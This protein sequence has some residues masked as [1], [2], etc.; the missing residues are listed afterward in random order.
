MSA[1]NALQE[2][3]QK[4]RL[5]TPIYKCSRRGGTD[6]SPLFKARV[7]LHDRRVFKATGPNKKKAESNAAKKALK[8][9]TNKKSLVCIPENT[10][11]KKFSSV[12][13]SPLEGRN[14]W[15]RLHPRLRSTKKT[16]IFIDLE[17]KHGLVESLVKIVDNDI[18]AFAS[19]DHPSLLKLKEKFKDSSNQVQLVEVPCTRKDG[20]DIGLVLSVGIFLENY[21][22]MIIVTSDHFVDA[23]AD[24][25]NKFD[26]MWGDNFKPPE[27]ICCRTLESILKALV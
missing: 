1:K 14:L 25:I 10:E 9:L 17:N 16:C 4:R 23:L 27:A 2:Y 7:T 11:I 6:H 5:N 18:I 22:K 24:C 19:T 15:E 13:S 3:Y 12:I 20:A 26:Q 8:Y 21:D